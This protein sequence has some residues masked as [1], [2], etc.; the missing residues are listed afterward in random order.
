MATAL[1]SQ[2]LTDLRAE[3]AKQSRSPVDP[4]QLQRVTE[5]ASSHREWASSILG[6]PFNGIRSLRGLELALLDLA[7]EAEP[8]PPAPVRLPAQPSPAEIAA[9][10]SARSADAA[11]GDLV[12]RFPVRV[13]VAYNFS[14]PLH[15]ETYASGAD[16]IILLAD[17]RAGRLHRAEG[18]SLCHTPSR[19]RHLLFDP[20][21][22]HPPADRTPTCK[23]CIR[24]AYRIVGRDADPHLLRKPSRQ[25]TSRRVR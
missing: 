18:R 8:E 15:V 13:G 14:G 19:S 4:R 2:Q 9:A 22:I 20:T 6:R 23:E 3:A 5:F 11:W 17:V 24:T 21:Q 10:E 1:T 16:H 12:E 7:A 25:V